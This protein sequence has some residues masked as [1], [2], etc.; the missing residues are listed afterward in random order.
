MGLQ[1]AQQINLFQ[2]DFHQRLE[3]VCAKNVQMLLIVMI[4]LLGLIT[5]Y[6]YF[7]ERGQVDYL[8]ELQAQQTELQVALQNAKQTA[9]S[10]VVDEKLKQQVGGYKNDVVIKQQVLDALS[11][12]S[13]GNTS[14]FSG[15]FKGLATQNVAGLWLTN[16]Q[17]RSGGKDIGISGSAYR[18][19]LVPEFLEKLSSE[20][21]FQG[22]NFQTF[23]V[24]RKKNP[25]RIDFHV[26]TQFEEMTNE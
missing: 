17:I 22:T 8:V 4:A 7:I 23:R 13:F 25:L 16:L 26:D 1:L 19:E 18:P 20:R 21:I 9:P 6:D 2:S 10:M 3:L 11:G 24:K 14:G 5:A 12:E 15:F